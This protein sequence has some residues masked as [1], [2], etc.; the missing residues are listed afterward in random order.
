MSW[1]KIKKKKFWRVIFSY[2]VQQPQTISQS[3]CDMRQRVGFYTTGDNLLSD[4]T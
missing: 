1:L 2:A 3:D 4:W